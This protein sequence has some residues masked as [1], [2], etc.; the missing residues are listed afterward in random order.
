[1]RATRT[2]QRAL[3]ASGA[4]RIAMAARQGANRVSV[5]WYQPLVREA[6]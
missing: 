3:T 4:V 2:L 5:D 6:A 1:M